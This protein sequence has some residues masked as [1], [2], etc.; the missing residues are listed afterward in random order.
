M[1]DLLNQ[2]RT[3]TDPDQ[4][5]DL[6]RQARTRQIAEDAPVDWLY[7][8][9]SVVVASPDLSGYPTFDVNDRF[10][11]SGIVLSD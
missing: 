3:A 5:V 7:L 10:D 9:D 2:A 6:T 11:A 4:A 1:Q 8:A